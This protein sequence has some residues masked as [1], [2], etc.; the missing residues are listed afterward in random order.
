MGFF[1]KS[2][3]QG[4]PTSSQK[5]DTSYVPPDIEEKDDSSDD[6]MIVLDFSSGRGESQKVSN[7]QSQDNDRAKTL[8]PNAKKDTNETPSGPMDFVNID[9]SEAKESSELQASKSNDA[10][11]IESHDYHG[12][13]METDW[14]SVGA[15]KTFEHERLEQLRSRAEDGPFVLRVILVWALLVAFLTSIVVVIQAVNEDATKG[16]LSHVFI[17]TCT[18]FA[19]AAILLAGSRR[20]LALG[21]FE[22]ILSKLHTFVMKHLGI[23]RLVWGRGVFCLVLGILHVTHMN[24]LTTITGVILSLVG[25]VAFLLG[26]G[27]YKQMKK[28]RHSIENDSMLLLDFNDKDLDQDGYINVEGFSSM[29]VDLDLDIDS[30]QTIREFHSIDKDRDGKISYKEFKKWMV[31]EAWSFERTGC[32]HILS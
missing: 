11:D 13:N 18:F 30:Q 6:D 9:A 24:T 7:T 17:S 19:G 23:L 5:K 26:V 3:K 16:V 21:N 2:K 25:F 15:D 1:T 4:K 8:N 12:S 22:G 31:E 14:E 29:V 32:G 28:V 20:P 10:K 27:P